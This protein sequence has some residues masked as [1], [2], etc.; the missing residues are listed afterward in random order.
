[1]TI[2]RKSFRS[3]FLDG[4]RVEIPAIQRDYA[5]GRDDEHSTEVRRRFLATLHATLVPPAGE[6]PTLDLDFV[7]GRQRDDGGALEPLD[8]QQRL[9]TLFLLHWY[10]A[11]LEGSFDE[12]RSWIAEPGRGSSFTYRTRPSAWDFIDALVQHPAPLHELPRGPKA[13]SAWLIDVVWFIHAWRRDPTVGACLNMLDAIHERFASASGAWARLTSLEAPA[14]TFRLLPLERFALSDELYVKMNARGKALTAFEVFKAELEQFVTETQGPERRD[15]LAH[16]LDTTWTDFLWKHHDGTRQ[17]DARFMALVRAVAVARCVELDDSDRLRSQVEALLNQPSPSLPTYLELG[18]LDATFID[19]V[20]RFLDALAGNGQPAF[21]GSTAFVDERA[22]FRRVLLARDAKATDG[23]NLT[24]WVLFYAWCAFVRRF[25][26]SL[27]DEGGRA[28][29]HDWMRIVANL[30]RNTDIERTE[31]LVTVLVA[32]HA[33]VSHAGPELLARVAGGAL[34]AVGG[35]GQ[36]QIEEER[37]KARL[38]LRNAAWRL[39]L[40]RAE[41]HAYFQGGIDFLLRFAGIF[42]RADALGGCAWD[43]AEDE[44]LR[45]AFA[46]LYAKAIAVFPEAAEGVAAFP[47]YLWERALL[48]TGDYLLP[49]SRNWSF[50][51]NKGSDATWKRLLRSDTKVA[52]RVARREVVRQ[53][54]ERLDPAD[55]EGSLR[56]IVAEGAAGSDPTGMRR[57]LVAEARLIQYCGSRELR[58]EDQTVYLLSKQQRNGYH[59][60]LYVYDLFLRVQDH[61]QKFAPFRSPVLFQPTDSYALSRFRLASWAN[62]P[63]LEVASSRGALQLR[64]AS[65]PPPPLAGGTGLDLPGWHLAAQGVF[66]LAVDPDDAESAVL[67]VAARLAPLGPEA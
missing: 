63:W 54:L 14:V 28:V 38:I 9:T 42:D 57:R 35:F 41:A 24:D 18:C 45:L 22:L 33:L 65:L 44:A 23:L 15:A 21:I 34:D 32:T 37:L 1:M 52:D 58:Y 51:V 50:L 61:L 8:G 29:F 4:G 31:R 19:E 47:E 39:L 56:R 64:L 26:R 60:D 66:D 53:V 62:G 11:S 16:R 3:L 25:A 13:L 48:A 46:D 27:R 59:V 17:I 10:L 12:F 40:E 7:Y 67:A 2:A 49:R 55:P 20:T 43:N 30:A 5:Q 6:S 36:Q